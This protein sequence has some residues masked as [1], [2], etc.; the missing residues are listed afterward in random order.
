MSNFLNRIFL[1]LLILAAA[2][3]M[4]ISIITLF[5]LNQSTDDAILSLLHK[6][7]YQSE[8]QIVNL[9]E[10]YS[11]SDSPY[12]INVSI[13]NPSISQNDL[14][15]LD[16]YSSGR[17]VSES[18]CIE[19]SKDSTDYQDQNSLTCLV[20]VPYSYSKTS[21]YSVFPRYR[22]NN[23]EY[24]GNIVKLHFDWSEY[25]KNLNSFSISLGL[26]TFLLYLLVVLPVSIFAIHTSIT[27]KHK[28]RYSIHNL[29]NPFLDSKDLFS[30]I[31]SFLVSPYFWSIELFGVVIVLLYMS[32]YSSAWGGFWAFLI[33]LLC[34]LIAFVIPFLWC[35]GWWYADY[36]EREPLR[37]IVTF[38]FWGM[39]AS[40]MAIG[41]NSLAGEL[42]GLIGFGV[43]GTVLAAPL[44]EEF[45]KGSG[46]ALLSEHHEFNSV[47]DGIVY[48][49]AIG[50]GF[51]FIE[52]WLYFIQNPLGSDIGSWIWLVI[53]RSIVFSAN[54][55][56]YTAIPGA[57][58]GYLIERKFS[59]P[60]L[61][62][63]I[64]LPFAA[65]LHMMH[66]SSE[67]MTALFG[68]GGIL[69]YCCFLIPIFDYGGAIFI[70]GLFI[71]S[72]LRKKN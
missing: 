27:A 46:L 63:L 50:M 49:F 71:R 10:N 23:S 48:G 47:E 12:V 4:L 56:F 51:S 19:Q 66:N 67:V 41:I 44:C 35:L 18:D 15:Y 36:R 21:T 7:N 59:F 26:L 62:L 54:H 53:M 16:V 22:R 58:I 29:F 30:K 65:F 3:G 32:M 17:L 14:L 72:V 45:F 28:H 6:Y 64:A 20:S 25:E 60:A 42:F 61:G 8:I 55:G 2:T 57:V 1:I 13:K 33:F 11:A 38:F 69:V 70:I 68:T 9:S 24:I 43:L 5:F 31:N 39:L 52:N 37:I 40:L 34:G